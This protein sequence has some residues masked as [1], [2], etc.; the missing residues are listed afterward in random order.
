MLT[1][2]EALSTRIPEAF[3]QGN[4]KAKRRRHIAPKDVDS[5]PKK[6]A[7]KSTDAV[8]V[9]DNSTDSDD[10]DDEYEYQFDFD[11]QTGV[12]FAISP[13]KEQPVNLEA[14][15]ESAA[16]SDPVVISLPDQLRQIDDFTLVPQP[17]GTFSLKSESYGFEVTVQT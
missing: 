16:S 15:E 6:R 2:E 13:K 3:Y 17:D 4:K 8:S 1:E 5:P 11:I 10:D 7:K 14:E 12:S 9:T